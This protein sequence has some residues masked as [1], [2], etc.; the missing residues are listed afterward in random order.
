MTHLFTY[1]VIN[2]DVDAAA[3]SV[4]AI[5]EA[6]HCRYERLKGLEENILAR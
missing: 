2:D 5:A 6:E 1:V 3:R 4:L